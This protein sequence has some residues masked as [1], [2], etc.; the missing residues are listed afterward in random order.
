MTK[1][2]KIYV[3]DAVSKVKHL[4]GMPIQSSHSQLMLVEVAFANR[5]NS[6]PTEMDAVAFLLNLRDKDSFKLPD[7][8]MILPVWKI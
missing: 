8:I 4:S 6:F 5:E 2:Y 3:Q 7:P 1:Q